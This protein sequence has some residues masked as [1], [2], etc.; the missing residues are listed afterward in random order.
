MRLGL[1]D[2]IELRL[3]GDA[4]MRTRETDL[5]TQETLHA[6]GWADSGI[7]IKW[8]THEGDAKKG[9]PTIG[10]VFRAELPTGSRAF[11]TGGVRPSVLGS[12]EWELRDEMAFAINAGLTYD[13]DAMEGRFVSG[14][15]GAGLSKG[16]TERLTIAAEVVAQ[17]IAAS[18]YG[19]TI[20]VADVGVKYLF[21]DNLQ[22]DALVGRGV[23]SESPKYLFTVGVS[24]R[25]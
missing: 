13:R 2:K 4:R 25:F 8:N 22:V 10:W 18:K 19:G 16:L 3:D 5:A 11:R 14:F 9:T 12:F 17:Q 23:T 24:A 15:L 21:T 1:T 6:H 20:A 7:G